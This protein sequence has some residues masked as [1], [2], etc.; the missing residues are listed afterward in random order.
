LP[1]AATCL[2]LEQIGARDWSSYGGWGS[3][4]DASMRRGWVQNRRRKA[5]V[6]VLQ[7]IALFGGEGGVAEVQ[8]RG[9][10]WLNLIV[11]PQDGGTGSTIEIRADLDA[12]MYT[13]V[14]S[15]VRGLFVTIV[16]VWDPT[17]P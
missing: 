17:V 12:E 11:L 10:G 9:G 16:R 2:A 13:S 8:H 3:Y 4:A 7:L 5:S 15:A 1:V 14:R 6:F